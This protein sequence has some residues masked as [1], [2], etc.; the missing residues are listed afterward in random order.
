M[1]KIKNSLFLKLT[2]L[3]TLV[4]IVP[5]IVSNVIAYRLNYQ[6]IRQQI[7]DW[8][9]NMLE[10]GMEQTLKFIK[11]VE[12]SPLNV[13]S[14]ADVVRIL[15]KQGTYTDMDRYVIRGYEKTISASVPA[16][17]R[18]I[19]ECQN[20]ESV[21]GTFV[22][23]SVTRM[24]ISHYQYE[25]LSNEK[26]QIGTN[27]K[28]EPS[29]LVYN[30]EI[31][32]V[33][34][35]DKLVDCHIF[36]NLDEFDTIAKELCGQYE[37]S[38][39]MVYLGDSQKKL[40]YSSIL[41]ETA[42]YDQDKL[43]ETDYVKGTLDGRKGIFFQ[44]EVLYK[45][46]E[47]QLI[48][49]VDNHWFEEP[50]R[51]VVYSAMIIQICL[52]VVSLIFLFLVFNIFIAPVRRMLENMKNVERN[53]DFA[54]TAGTQR[55]DELGVL[56]NQ[57]EGMMRSLDELVNKNYRNQ[58]EMSKSR[59]KMLQAQINPHFLYNMLQYISTTALQHQCP[60]VST[61]L[62]QLGE[63][64]QYTCGADEESVE[65]GKELH[66]L[67]NYMSLQEGRFGGRMHFMIRCPE[68]LEHLVIP[69]MILQPLVE[70]S[71]KHGID[72]RDG[73]GNI[74]VAV[75][76]KDNAY[77]IRVVDNG[78]GMT[79][80]QIEILKKDYQ[81][82]KF[83]ANANHGIGFLNVLQRCQIFYGERFRWQI[84]SIPDI[85]TTVELVIEKESAGEM[86]ES[87]N[88]R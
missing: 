48:K 84:R 75:M 64:F 79:Q 13:F 34:S 19:L 82:Y 30:V 69:K 27:E 36:A 39:V 25:E 47:V 66:H 31:Q 68:E 14:Q 65:L 55:K 35:Y 60:E 21:E 87:A 17:Y 74:L 8:N 76:E 62:T 71:I 42:K 67:E 37:D 63:L 26:F 18:V 88:R 73:I 46:T 59:Y 51:K 53:A 49:F 57:Y 6:Q 9:A 72:K 86:D 11:E 10:I 80:E 20:G 81:A 22:Q 32:N 45:G 15:K 28:G 54:Y 23:D 44:N 2:V 29:C 5:S 58:L 1:S 38:V 61:Q 4:I 78:S 24:R 33:P 41:F 52:L 7:V 40:L 77:H 56:E 70:N 85:E 43:L 16:I 50:A 83:T 12:Q 3:L